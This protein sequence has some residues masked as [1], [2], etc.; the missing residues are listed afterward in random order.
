MDIPPYI[1]APLLII[2][3]LIVGDWIRE[4]FFSWWDGRR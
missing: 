4:T 1:A 3:A 2:L